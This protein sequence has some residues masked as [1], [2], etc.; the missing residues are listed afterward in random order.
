[1]SPKADI[2]YHA[3]NLGKADSYGSI[4][5]SS[6]STGHFGTGTYFVG[7]EQE[8]SSADSTYGKRPHEQ[9]DF[10]NYHLYKPYNYKEAQ[11]AFQFLK[12]VNYY[13]EDLEE[14]RRDYLE[15]LYERPKLI[16]ACFFV[17]FPVEYDFVM[18]EILEA[19]RT[20][21]PE[22]KNALRFIQDYIQRTGIRKNVSEMIQQT[23]EADNSCSLTDEQIAAAFVLSYSKEHDPRVEFEAQ[24]DWYDSF[25]Y[26]SRPLGVDPETLDRALDQTREYVRQQ[27][28]RQIQMSHY[29]QDSP[30]TFFMKLLGY[31]G[32][33]VRHIPEMDNTEFGSVIYDLKGE[34]RKRAQELGSKFYPKPKSLQ[35][36]MSAAEQ[37]RQQT[38]NENAVSVL[39]N[40]TQHRESKTDD[41]S[42]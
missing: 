3:G 35:E 39:S 23:R 12:G 17:R 4:M 21:T 25:R 29:R 36:K 15:I 10:S 9:V 5:G 38:M 32:V 24:R 20:G 13:I 33:D 6:R 40:G 22:Y 11:K 27:G 19:D 2:G 18:D 16:D 28:G 34:D 42:L 26:A 31:E 41:L 7:N 14:A 1:M 30:S 8:I 37:T